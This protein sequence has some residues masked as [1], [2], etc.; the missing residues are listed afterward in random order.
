MREKGTDPWTEDMH[1]DVVVKRKK[2]PP[3][4][5]EDGL[6]FYWFARKRFLKSELE[7]LMNASYPKTRPNL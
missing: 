1:L 5:Q 4:Y 2:M 7:E 3:L 6:Y